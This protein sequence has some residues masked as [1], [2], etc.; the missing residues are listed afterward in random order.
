VKNMLVIGA[1]AGVILL[2]CVV[3]PP[4]ATPAARPAPPRPRVA[5]PRPHTDSFGAGETPA[6]AAAAAAPG[7]PAAELPHPGVAVARDVDALAA[8]LLA[9]PDEQLRLLVG[10]RAMHGYVSRVLSGFERRTPPEVGR[11]PEIPAFLEQ[12]NARILSVR[13]NG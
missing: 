2:V 5:I 6:A 13:S 7:A 4:A 10:S 3:K 9:L 12:L 1:M 11:S 8:W